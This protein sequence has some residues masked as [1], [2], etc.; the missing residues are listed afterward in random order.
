MGKCGWPFLILKCF[1]FTSGA[2]PESRM[3]QVRT[4]GRFLWRK[5]LVYLHSMIRI[6][7]QRCGFRRGFQ[8]RSSALSQRGN[9][10]GC[11]RTR[12]R[13]RH[14]RRKIRFRPHFDS[15]NALADT[16][17]SDNPP[18]VTIPLKHKIIRDWNILKWRFRGMRR[19]ANRIYPT[20]PRHLT[21][22]EANAIYNIRLQI[23]DRTILSANEARR[24]KRRLERNLRCKINF[25]LSEGDIVLSCFDQLPQTICSQSGNPSLSMKRSSSVSD[26]AR[27]R[28]QRL[29]NRPRRRSSIQSLPARPRTPSAPSR[30]ASLDK[31]AIV[32]RA[33]EPITQVISPN[34]LVNFDENFDD[35]DSSEEEE[36]LPTFDEGMT[37]FIPPIIV[38]TSPA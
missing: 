38:I 7:R 37:L 33:A 3:V 30:P 34:V 28:I 16:P 5:V 29:K 9:A 10:F 36:S 17:D 15:G 24:T 27:T 19:F 35:D 14:H 2:K 18:F 20:Y 21:T 6:R 26:E 1:G 25:D 12:R 22:P 32:R 31:I 8:T 11:F 13:H 23:G 4:H